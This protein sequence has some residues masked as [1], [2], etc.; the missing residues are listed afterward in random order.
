M[1]HSN[2][3]CIC[4]IIGIP[5]LEVSMIRIKLT[6]G[7]D[8]TLDRATSYSYDDEGDLSITSGLKEIAT[9]ARGQW[10]YVE[11]PPEQAS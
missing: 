4:G 11:I 5:T 6:T 3:P 8:W 10:V 9:V 1:I 2:P 7:D